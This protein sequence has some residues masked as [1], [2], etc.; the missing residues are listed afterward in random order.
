L[1]SAGRADAL[2]FGG[3]PLL[4][5][6]GCTTVEQGHS[7]PGDLAPEPRVE[8]VADGEFES[9]LIAAERTG[10]YCYAM[11]I[12]PL[13]VEVALRRWERFSGQE[14]VRLDG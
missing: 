13:Y 14:A 7:G 5:S 3:R 6:Q 2:A 1:A 12:D 10:T 4:G 8:G 11:E 9:A